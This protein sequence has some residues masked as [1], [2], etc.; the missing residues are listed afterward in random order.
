MKQVVS[1]S[2]H[3]QNDG[4]AEV[5]IKFIKCTMKICIETNND[6]NLVLL[7][8]RSR[9]VGFHLLI[10]TTWLLNRPKTGVMLRISTMLLKYAYDEGN[11]NTLKTQHN[12]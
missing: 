8:I 6:I 4:Q 11:H 5:C 1:S 9:P 3:H 2:F 7:Q 10:P 12:T